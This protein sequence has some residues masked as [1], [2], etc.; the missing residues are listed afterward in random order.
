MNVLCH[1]NSNAEAVVTVLSV[2]MLFHESK[3]HQKKNQFGVIYDHCS[4]GK[5][6][7]EKI[8]S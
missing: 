2:Q 3:K 8:G 7:K 5:Q 1:F 6:G 4:V